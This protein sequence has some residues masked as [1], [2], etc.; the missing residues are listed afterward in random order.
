MEKARLR[1]GWIAVTCLV[2]SMA[3]K[4]ARPG[5]AHG[6]GDASGG[7]AVTGGA[8]TGG[9][10]QGGTPSFVDAAVFPF[11]SPGKSSASDVYGSAVAVDD[12]TVVVGAY[13]DY[14]DLL[15]GGAAHIYVDSGAGY[16]LQ[17][18]LRPL[19]PQDEAF[20]GFAV[21]IDGDVVAAGAP[22]YSDPNVDVAG[23]AYLFTRSGSSWL[24]QVELRQNPPQ[25]FAKFGGAVAVSGDTALIAAPDLAARVFVYE[26]IGADWNLASELLAANPADQFG[27]AVALEGDTAL[28]G[29]LKVTGTPGAH[30]FVRQGGSWVEEQR[31]APGI[32]DAGF[33]YAVDLSGDTAVIGTEA[34]TGKGA[35]YVFERAEGAWQPTAVLTADDGAEG[36]GFGAAV[37]IDGGVIVVGAHGADAQGDGSGAAYVFER[38]GQGWMQQTKLLRPGGEAGDKFGVAVA[39]DGPVAVVG[40]ANAATGRGSATIFRAS[41]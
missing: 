27:L 6:G 15:V 34:E 32:G 8:A 12:G 36:D 21:A 19:V 22:S 3:C 16:E 31:L 17:A 14:A 20:F 18:S 2:G 41:P 29:G 39:V 13:R 30:V 1:F 24:G 10:G 33:G 38:A 23:A 37:A 25:V 26:R 28:V 11:E 7:G 40:G 9:A 4:D 5:Q 35:A